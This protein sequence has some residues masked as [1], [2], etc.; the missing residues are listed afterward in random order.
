MPAMP[1]SQRMVAVSSTDAVSTPSPSMQHG[2][3]ALHGNI[4]EDASFKLDVSL[5]AFCI[6]AWA[7]AVV[8]A[9][10]EL[11]SLA[12]SPP[13]QDSRRLALVRVRPRALPCRRPDGP[14]RSL[15]SMKSCS[16]RDSSA[17]P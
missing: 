15:S 13:P 14:L 10:A 9:T 8:V 17:S 2:D 12:P 3:M 6:A 16:T 1:P 11:P 4:T 7:S 5:P